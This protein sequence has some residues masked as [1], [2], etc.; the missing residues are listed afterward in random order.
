MK[1][2]QY[3][4]QLVSINGLTFTF[5]VVVVSQRIFQQICQE[6][7]WLSPTNR[8]SASLEAELLS[9]K[10]IYINVGEAQ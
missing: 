10:S 3:M 9:L 4:I 1:N 8:Q 5:Q 7:L 2:Y 6:L